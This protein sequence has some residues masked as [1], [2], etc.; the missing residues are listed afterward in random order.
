MAEKPARALWTSAEREW[1]WKRSVCVHTYTLLPYNSVVEKAIEVSHRWFR[2][3]PLSC[4]IRSCTM[5]GRPTSFPVL[6]LLKCSASWLQGLCDFCSKP[7]GMT[8]AL[9]THQDDMCWKAQPSRLVDCLKTTSVLYMIWDFSYIYNI[10]HS[11]WRGS[12][13]EW[14]SWE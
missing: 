7:S 9:G 14:W 13:P 5:P 3:L 6:T 11:V 8:M 12:C 2:V 10:L 4:L 1:E